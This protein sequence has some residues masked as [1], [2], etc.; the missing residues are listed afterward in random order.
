M[1]AAPFVLEQDNATAAQASNC[2][3]QQGR[4]I[5]RFQATIGKLQMTLLAG[6][7]ARQI[8]I[9]DPASRVRVNVIQ[10]AGV[11]FFECCAEQAC[12]LPDA[13]LHL[14]AGAEDERA[15]G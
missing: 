12:E 4:N 15:R 14:R 5:T 10:T 8:S 9:A 2:E 3:R 13:A 1:Q 7:I 11:E 6:P